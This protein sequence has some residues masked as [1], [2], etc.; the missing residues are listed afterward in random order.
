MDSL[1]FL[2]TLGVAVAAIAWYV[3]NE[4]RHAD[5]GIGVF[6][7]GPKDAAHSA[8]RPGDGAPRFRVRQ[9]LTPDRGTTLRTGRPARAYRFKAQDKPAWRADAS[10]SVETT[11]DADKE[12]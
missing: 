12:Y 3:E 5:G 4:A 10:R 7:I 6:A 8:A 2:I 11:I 1:A 9:R